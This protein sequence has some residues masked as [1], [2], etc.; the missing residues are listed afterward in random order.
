MK[1]KM[2]NDQ[3]ITMVINQ[4]GTG[5]PRRMTLRELG[6]NGEESNMR[7]PNE[8]SLILIQR[9]HIYSNKL[10]V[11]NVGGDFF[12]PAVVEEHLATLGYSGNSLN[13]DL[14]GSTVSGYRFDANKG[15][16][17]KIVELPQA[18]L[19]ILW[20]SKEKDSHLGHRFRMCTHPDKNIYYIPSEYCPHYDDLTDFPVQEK[21]CN[22]LVDNTGTEAVC[23]GSHMEED[24]WALFDTLCSRDYRHGAKKKDNTT[25]D[26]GISIY[27]YY[28]TRMWNKPQSRLLVA[29][30]K[31]G[32]KICTGYNSVLGFKQ[33]MQDNTVHHGNFEL[34]G[35]DIPSGVIA[36]W[37][38]IP[39]Y[40]EKQYH[41][42]K[43][44]SGF[45]SFA[46][47]GENYLNYDQHP[48]SRNK[49]LENCGVIY[50]P[51]KVVVVFELP[52]EL[53]L[54]T[55][56]SRTLLYSNDNKL[57]DKN[58]FHEAFRVNM[59]IELRDWL[60][61]HEIGREKTEDISKWLKK[62]FKM[63]IYG[64]S[65][66]A[67]LPSINSSSNSS[68]NGSKNKGSGTKGDSNKT[69]NRINF[70]GKLKNKV[71]PEISFVDDTSSENHM[72]Q[73]FE[74][75]YKLV[76]NVGN[77]YYQQNLN[78][79]YDIFDVCLIKD[80]VNDFMQK[81]LAKNAI[82][83]IFQ[84]EDLERSCSA[85]ER[86]EL[87]RPEILARC[88]NISDLEYIQKKLDLKNRKMAKLSA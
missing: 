77:K 70:R 6:M 64:N 36:H 82:A 37:C 23:L 18:K 19:G 84:T 21:F 26:T 51:D 44:S 88:I 58:L 85:E 71:V 56:S 31:S 63:S 35:P 78:H 86:K 1:I 3:A 80:T 50:K 81:V 2:N 8:E 49:D 83:S 67:N 29:Q 40:D 55:N 34:T 12:S 87:Y 30:Y 65:N 57:L 25:R 28:N 14:F 17:A 32:T 7:N 69:S 39:M 27:R 4:L 41:S 48:K 54:K 66:V 42:N 53:E 38:V 47:K 79:I 62:Q 45:T 10:S 73:F 74:K 11:I 72:V 22:N 76:I 20:R 61:S 15:I 75:D 24:T 33:F 13:K 46:W 43:A 52:S 59:P 16:G 5:A 60:E 68:S 9:D